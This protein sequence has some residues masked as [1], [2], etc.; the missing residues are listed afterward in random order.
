MTTAASTPSVHGESIT[1]ASPADGLATFPVSLLNGLPDAVVALDANWRY[2]YLNDAARAHMRALG[3]DPDD[4]IGRVVFDVFPQLANTEIEAQM[5]R[6]LEQRVPTEQ[7]EVSSAIGRWFAGRF[8]PLPNGGILSIARD[9]SDRKH[10]EHE[11]RRA[12]RLQHVTSALSRA[13]TRDEVARLI[14]DVG[15]DAMD[16][17]AGTVAMLAGDANDVVSIIRTVGH[18]PERVSEWEGPVD[19]HAP[20]QLAIRTREIVTYS[21][22]AERRERFGT[23]APSGYESGITVPLLVDDQVLG[24]WGLSFRERRTFSSEERDFV[25]ALAAQAAQALERSRLLDAERRARADAAAAQ[26]RSTA[27]LESIHDGFV[28]VDSGWRFTYVNSRAAQMLGHANGALLGRIVWEVLPQHPDAPFRR[29]FERAVAQH[30]PCTLEE[31]S[32]AT[33]R[34]IEVRVYPS[35]E[36][37]TLFFRDVTEERRVKEDEAFLSRAGEVFGN[38]VDP[39]ATLR[40]L[41]RLSVPSLADVAAVYVLDE[42]G[43]PVP[44]ASAFFDE[45][46][47]EGMRRLIERH[48]PE[49]SVSSIVTRVARAR[50]PELFTE[51]RAAH[52]QQAS[53]DAQL[54]ALLRHAAPRSALVVPI[55]ARGAAIG[56]LVLLTTESSGRSYGDR[57]LALAVELARRAALAVDNARLRR[58]AVAANAAKANFLAVIS[59]ELRT[60]LTAIIGYSELLAEEIVGPVNEMQ[61]EQ[62]LR[63]KSSSLQLLTLIEE[64]LSF[65]RIESGHEPVQLEDVDLREVANTV[66]AML[67]PI[68]ERKALRLTID[69]P[70]RP[71]RAQTDIA[72]LRQILLNLMSNAVKFTEVGEVRLEVI[73]NGTAAML[74]VQD[75]GIGIASEHLEHVFDAFWQAEHPATRRFGGTGLGLSVAR[76]LAALLGAE[77]EVESIEGRGTTFTIKVG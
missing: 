66:G 35:A 39:N 19:R 27:V 4:A 50:Q 37:T 76:R 72:K 18:S 7:P 45:S 68:A 15:L 49:R 5:R 59:H 51:V 57:D 62:L 2:T 21:S 24:C 69:V 47:D 77:L 56:V 46:R 14:L 6:A 13:M 28:A 22:S 17:P 25:R 36:G 38:A 30:E 73:P 75:T 54:L 70:A 67:R 11:L 42:S 3:V 61:R 53:A 65:A 10:V 20:I 34:W 74:R 33:R 60:P 44:V 29:A 58:D 8:L 31:Y 63:V 26:A 52:L 43:A 32:T 16:A 48:R 55:A 41:A 12:Q 9:V 1:S 64:I 23:P 71:V 40:S